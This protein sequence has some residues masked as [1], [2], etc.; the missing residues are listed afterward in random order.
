MGRELASTTKDDGTKISYTYNQ[1]ELRQT[2]TIDG[3]KTYYTIVGDKITSQYTYSDTENILYFRYNEDGDL[4][5]FE[6]ND[7]Q[8]YYVKNLQKDIIGILDSDGNCVVEYAY[9]PWGDITTITGSMKDTLGKLNPFRYRSYYYDNETGFYY[10]QSRYYDPTT[11]R[12]INADSADYLWE[13]GSALVYNFFEYGENSPICNYDPE[14]KMAV[15]FAFYYEMVKFE[16]YKYNRTK[17][18]DYANK[19]AFWHNPKYENFDNIKGAGD[20]ANFVSQCLYSGGF[21]MKKT[22]GKS[23]WYSKKADFLERKIHRGNFVCAKAWS[24][25]HEQ[26]KYFKQHYTVKEYKIKSVNDIKKTASKVKIGDL[27]YFDFTS[28]GKID[29]ST[30]ITRT[31]K[32]DIFYNGHTDA[33]IRSPLSIKFKEKYTCYVLSLRDSGFYIRRK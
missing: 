3:V 13:S 1:D 19:W 26:Y 23:G 6:Y 33:Y 12:F 20:C 18:K 22:T 7:E 25:A 30:I 11:C 5:A 24:L 28:D 31:V 14:G 15:S 4:V 29:H 27:L 21:P 32:S 9:N 17:A 2:K 8:Y 10:L 16:K